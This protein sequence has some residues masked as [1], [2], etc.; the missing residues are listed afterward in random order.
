MDQD[1]I[2]RYV[3]G[4]FSGVDVQIAS[5]ENGAPEMAW[6]DTFFIFDPEITMSFGWLGLAQLEC[7]HYLW[8]R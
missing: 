5:R 6:G 8:T 4:A 3:A 1:G 7:F 2:R